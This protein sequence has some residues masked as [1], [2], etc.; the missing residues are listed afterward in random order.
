[1]FFKP[2][3]LA[4]FAGSLLT[5]GL[6]VGAAFF[7]AKILLHWNLHS[8]SEL[9]LNLERRTYLISTLVA[10]AFAFQLLSFFLF[11]F[12]ADHLH[13]FFAG[14][15]CAAGSL[16]ANSWGYPAVTLKVVNFLLAGLWLVVNYT[17]NKGYDYPLIRKKYVLLLAITPVIL[18][19]T[20]AQANYFLH[21]EPEVITSCCGT[22][23]TADAKG[24]ASDIVAVPPLPME[25]IFSAS[26]AA[27]LGSGFYFYRTGKAG[28]LFSFLTL[29]TFLI[30]IASLLS[31]ISP[32]IYELPTH[33]CPFCLLQPEYH[34]IGYPIYLSILG[35]ALAGMGAGVLMPFRA[36]ASLNKSLPAIQK[37][38]TIVTLIFYSSFTLM[39]VYQII[40][41]NL[42]M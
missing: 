18:S 17:D 2:A 1:M 40:I 39:V 4:L 12:T 37:G 34:Y 31:F 33:H 15:M 7:G 29:L 35:G 41:S 25:I 32:Y 19:E 42:K 30:A 22:L 21:L 26:M 8:G 13:D 23:F 38:L 10:Y 28:Y 6:L 9:Q 11:I 16:N 3:I 27:T 14:A 20:I 5:S 36:I 24:I